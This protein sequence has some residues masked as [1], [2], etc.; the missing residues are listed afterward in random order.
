MACV[1]RPVKATLNSHPPSAT[2]AKP[3]STPP[4]R[5]APTNSTSPS[6]CPKLTACS[7]ELGV[8]GRRVASG[9]A[10]ERRR[11]RVERRRISPSTFYFLLSTLSRS[12]AGGEWRVATED[13]RLLPFAIFLVSC[14]M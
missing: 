5:P 1:A 6:F 4:A 12:V 13:D 10:G 8:G 9:C 14:S 7:V 3:T 2:G 11:E